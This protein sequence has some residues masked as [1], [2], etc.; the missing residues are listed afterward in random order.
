MEKDIRFP[1][2]GLPDVFLYI[3]IILQV[4]FLSLEAGSLSFSLVDLYFYQ[5]V[6]SSALFGFIQCLIRNSYEIAHKLRA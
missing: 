1:Y 2:M 6:C 4:F 5:S 3:F